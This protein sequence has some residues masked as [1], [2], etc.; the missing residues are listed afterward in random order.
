[1]NRLKVESMFA[2][3]GDIYLGFKQVDYYIVWDNEKDKAA[4]KIYRYNFGDDW[5]CE[6]YIRNF[7][8]HELPDMDVLT[9]GF[10]C[11][12]F[13]VAGVQKALMTQEEIC[14]FE[15]ARVIDLKRS[16]SNF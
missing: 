2:G 10:S 1:M 9:V 16:T 12:S 15:I 5:L 11:Q 4:C 13:S 8:T 14:F 6:G 7:S 3:I